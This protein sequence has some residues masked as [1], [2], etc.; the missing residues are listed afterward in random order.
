MTATFDPSEY[1]DTAPEA[2]VIQQEDI[3]T[4]ES[5]EGMAHEPYVIFNV[6]E[7]AVRAG[8]DD[9]DG[10]K[11]YEDVRLYDIGVRALDVDTLI[12]IPWHMVM[13]VREPKPAD[14][15]VPDVLREILQPAPGEDNE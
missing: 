9:I 5:T 7:V 15:E 4:P 6:A 1:D 13:F 10:L 11:L 3:P 12:V 2:I 14:A 8:H